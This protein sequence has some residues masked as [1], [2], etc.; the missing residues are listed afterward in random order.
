M[1]CLRPCPAL[2]CTGQD[3]VVAPARPL[4]LASS[5]RTVIAI[6]E[7]RQRPHNAACGRG[8]D[9]WNGASV[10]EVQGPGRVGG[11]RGLGPLTGRRVR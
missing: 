6:A 9:E 3:D 4:A 8:G 5:Q 10:D 7:P 11:E 2:P 1:P